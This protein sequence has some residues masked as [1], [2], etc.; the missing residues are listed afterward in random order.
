MRYNN[1]K[2]L[3]M[4]LLVKSRQHQ[5]FEDINGVIVSRKS[6]NDR[7]YSGQKK[8]NKNTNNDMQITT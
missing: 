7:Q 8:K 6:K 2:Y 5:Q 3:H 1:A 4:I